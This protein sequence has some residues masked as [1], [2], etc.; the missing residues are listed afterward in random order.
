MIRPF[1]SVSHAWWRESTTQALARTPHGV[2][3]TARG[4]G[5]A[6]ADHGADSGF[7]V[8]ADAASAIPAPPAITSAVVSAAV[9]APFTALVMFSQVPTL[10]PQRRDRDMTPI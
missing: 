10:T 1:A 4:P 2:A 5:G 6:D 3:D 7:V 8:V 9:A